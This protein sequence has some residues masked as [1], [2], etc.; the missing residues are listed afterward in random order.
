M[1]YKV[2]DM[3]SESVAV[4][5]WDSVLKETKIRHIHFEGDRYWI[6]LGRQREWFKRI[7]GRR[8]KK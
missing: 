8:D 6:S 7:K 2:L 1:E 4:T 5:R 3:D